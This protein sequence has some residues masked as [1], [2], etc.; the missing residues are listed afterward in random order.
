MIRTTE[1]SCASQPTVSSVPGYHQCWQR[2]GRHPKT[3]QRHTCKSPVRG[4]SGTQPAPGAGRAVRG[5]GCGRT[6][7]CPVGWLGCP[8]C[9]AGWLGGEPAG[10]S[11][12]AP[13]AEAR[14]ACDE[15]GA[16]AG[17]STLAPKMAALAAAAR[18]VVREARMASQPSGP[19]EEKRRSS[20]V[21]C[22][23]MKRYG[24]ENL[25]SVLRAL[26]RR[27]GAAPACPAGP[28]KDM[29]TRT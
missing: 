13:A 14:V 18:A 8:A 15:E 24:H 17:I 23:T 19:S 7:A 2:T 20:S 16:A 5:W 10:A 4:T 29:D 12:D 22:R 9:H 11:P 3:A 28:C 1:I 25:M 21:P 26:I 27:S 6:Y